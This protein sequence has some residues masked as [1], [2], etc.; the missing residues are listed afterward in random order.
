MQQPLLAISLSSLQLCLQQKRKGKASLSSLS[1]CTLRLMA[2]E[3]VTN[4]HR[5]LPPYPEVH[6]SVPTKLQNKNWPFFFPTLYPLLSLFKVQLWWI[7]FF[8][9]SIFNHLVFANFRCFNKENKVSFELYN[10]IIIFPFDP[11]FSSSLL[12]M[13]SIG[14]KF[15]LLLLSLISVL[16]LVLFIF[17]FF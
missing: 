3:E 16:L 2:T 1:L 8:F 6:H 9:F 14:S 4:K 17:V 10:N 5:P 13:S 15:F 12:R 11:H 7:N